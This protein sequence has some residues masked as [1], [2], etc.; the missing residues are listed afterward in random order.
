MYGL[1]T[2]FFICLPVVMFYAN[3]YRFK[4]GEG[5]VKTGSIIVS[6][7]A[8]DAT[9]LLDGVEVGRSGFL[10]RNFYISNLTPGSYVIDVA[11]EGDHAWRRTLVVEQEIVTDAQALL[12]SEEPEVVRLVDAT[13]AASSTISIP[14]ATYTAYLAAFN[15]PKKATTTPLVVA[16]KMENETVEVENG[17][18]VARWNNE[19][20]IPPSHFC[21]RPSSCTNEV[22]VER[23]AAQATRAEFFDGGVVYTTKEGGVFLGEVDIRPAPLTV[24][25]YAKRGA[26]FRIVDGHLIIKDGTVLYE[27]TGL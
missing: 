26:D 20:I 24:S 12:V 5:I 8:A 14:H 13:K 1:I 23:G 10:R 9:V 19:E 2:A 21:I 17:N 16:P 6:V 27:I 25:I 22:S 18:V 11:R 7:S 4:S 15:P 3:G